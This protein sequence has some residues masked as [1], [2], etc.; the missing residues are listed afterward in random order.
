MTMSSP[1]SQNQGGWNFDFQPQQQQNSFMAPNFGGDSFSN[2]GGYQNSLNTGSQ[3][4]QSPFGGS[5][6]GGVFDIF[7]K[8]KKPGGGAGTDWM[9]PEGF[10]AGASAAASIGK[11]FLGFQQ[12][13]QA[14]AQL[15]FQ[16][17]AFL[18]Q[19]NQQVQDRERRVAGA[20]AA[21][22]GVSRY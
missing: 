17:E 16:K 7:K 5:D 4:N 9:S 20:K 11:T 14:K 12:Q 13:K 8:D 2:G 1:G 15:A 21:A 18:S 19:F 3:W 10:A 6:D 22:E